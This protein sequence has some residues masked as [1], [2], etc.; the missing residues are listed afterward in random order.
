MKYCLAIIIICCAHMAYGQTGA[1]SSAVDIV[2]SSGVPVGACQPQQ[3]DINTLAG[4]LYT[5]QSGVWGAL[6]SASVINPSSV[7]GIIFVDGTTYP[8]TAAGVN[9]ALAASTNG[10]ETVF[11]SNLAT[12]NLTDALITL[13][14]HNRLY[15]LGQGTYVVGT[16][17]AA[18]STTPAITVPDSSTDVTAD[19]IIV[20]PDHAKIQLAAG[21]NRD[22]IA[23][24]NFFT[25][26]GTSNQFG[27]FKFT[28]QGCTLDG[29]KTNQAAL[30]TTA[31]CIPLNVARTA[32]GLVTINCS[33]TPSP[34][35]LAGYAV[36]VAGVATDGFTF[37]GHF[38]AQSATATS[39]TFNEN[40]CIVQASCHTTTSTTQP[41][42]IAITGCTAS[43]FTATCNTGSAHGFVPQQNVTMSGL[44]PAGYNGT[45]LLVTASGTSFTFVVPTSGLGASGTGTATPV[46]T[47]IGYG[48]A[49]GIKIYG[50]RSI[51]RDLVIANNTCDG[52]WDE[53]VNPPAFGDD[54]TQLIST[55]TDIQEMNSGCDGWVFWGPQ[56]SNFVN[57]DDFKHGHWGIEA[58]QTLWGK[59]GTSYLNGSGGIHNFAADVQLTNRQDASA[60]GWGILT[61]PTASQLVIS[62]SSLS[63]PIGIEFR[64]PGNSFQGLILNSAVGMKFNGG[65]VNAQINIFT[66]TTWFDCTNENA[67]VILDVSYGSTGGTMQGTNCWTGQ[68]SLRLPI[69]AGNTT[70][71]QFPS[72]L[73]GFHIG[74]WNPSFPAANNL[75]AEVSATDTTTTHFAAATATG[76]VLTTRAIATGD[77]PTA[78]PIGN[79]GTSGLSGTAPATISAAGAIGCATCV[80]S[81]ASIT[82]NVL[83]KGSGGAQGVAN[84]LVTDNGTA[85]TYTGTGGVLSSGNNAILTTD[86]TDT[87]SA[88]LQNVTG[89]SFT[90]PANTARNYEVD[91]N[92]M[93][94]QATFTGITDQFGLQDVTVAPT[95]IDGYGLMSV[96]GPGAV[97]TNAIYG[98][99][100]NLTTTTATS[101][102]SAIPTVATINFSQLHFTVQQPSNASTSVL[103][104]MV[105]QSTAADVIVVR[106]G[107]SCR[108]N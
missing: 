53:G 68:E 79:I 108:L 99:L 69:T 54:T 10:Q 51:M 98:V 100:T 88:S 44:T 80:T 81:A 49:G 55:Y 61:E 85:L 12:I 103:Q 35:F 105:S 6:P 25:L 27:T 96:A 41:V 23:D 40:Q 13:N 89:L 47:A 34:A 75:I 56:S 14:K 17:S 52:R 101:I 2:Q 1:A 33:N 48:G 9:S 97:I 102:V 20:C 63:A 38:I 84:S 93:W 39:F 18:Y 28:L 11:S 67:L 19:S 31:T 7:N 91:C 26:T 30:V 64:N 95:R 58:F 74:G 82:N 46:I 37:N 24:Q 5:C 92:L 73:T 60:V 15:L 87:S 77:L 43:G 45:Y 32:G 72:T 36:D 65:S 104:I 16:A 8:K 21:A 59:G 70:N 29:N 57:V 106:A 3:V 86:F 76:G 94:S 78:I 62:G 90:L 71:A 66:V 83:P 50:R 22:I 4:T 107:S 42:A